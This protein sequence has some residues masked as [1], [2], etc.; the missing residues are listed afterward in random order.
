MRLLGEGG[1]QANLCERA[2]ISPPIVY[3]CAHILHNNFRGNHGKDRAFNYNICN[4][5]LEISFF[6]KL[7]LSTVL[8]V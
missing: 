1:K 5:R 7:F 6:R 2:M 8:C 3:D 4:D